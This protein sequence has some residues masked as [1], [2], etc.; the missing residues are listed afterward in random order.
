MGNGGMNGG[1]GGMNGNNGRGMNQMQQPSNPSPPKKVD[2]IALAV[3]KLTK[4]LTLDTLQATILK[5]FLED[6]KKKEDLVFAEDIIDQAKMDKIVI[7]RD[8]L[9]KKLIGLLS[10]EQADKFAKMKENSKKK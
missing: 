1:M 10:K 9:D 2:V 5:G 3:D 8:N 7:L 4:D 6:M